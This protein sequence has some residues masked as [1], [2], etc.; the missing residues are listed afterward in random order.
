MPPPT[1]L[2]VED[3]EDVMQLASAGFADHG[4]DVI[5]VG[6]ATVAMGYLKTTTIHVLFTDLRMPGKMNGEALAKFAV[7]H[8]PATKIILTSGYFHEFDVNR[9]SQMGV[10]IQKPY[11][12]SRV[13]DSAL[14]LIGHK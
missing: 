5:A 12:I 14:R 9:L 8:F 10:L 7:D 6:D 11:R 2:V 4:F 3:D 13:V 1:V